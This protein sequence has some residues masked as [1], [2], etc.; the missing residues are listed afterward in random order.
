MKI[1]VIK[2]NWC[3]A[4]GLNHE[5]LVLVDKKARYKG[6]KEQIEAFIRGL[7]GN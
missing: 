7:Y 5:Y 2:Q 6:N 4:Q 1:E 3:E